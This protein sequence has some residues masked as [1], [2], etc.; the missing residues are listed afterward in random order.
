MGLQV[1][2]WVHPRPGQQVKGQQVKVCVCVLCLL[3]YRYLTPAAPPGRDGPGP[4]CEA[5]PAAGPP[6]DQQEEDQGCTAH[7]QPHLQR[8]GEPT[9]PMAWEGGEGSCSQGPTRQ[10]TSVTRWRSGRCIPQK[11]Q[12]STVGRRGN[13]ISNNMEWEW[14]KCIN[15]SNMQIYHTNYK[16]DLISLHIV[17]V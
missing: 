16:G 12:G 2:V 7:L 1:K 13:K 10:R 8:D 15:I 9:P 4:L 6:E 5:L 14:T 17:C 3:S 11:M